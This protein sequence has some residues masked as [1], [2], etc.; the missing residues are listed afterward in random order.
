MDY[1]LFLLLIYTS[2]FVISVAV[3]NLKILSPSIVFTAS[4]SIMIYLAYAT[5]AAMG[6]TVN[7]KTFMIFSVGGLLFVLTEM[8]VMIMHKRFSHQTLNG[9]GS[10]IERKPLYIRKSTLHILLFIILF[11]LL[12]SLISIYLSTS[13]SVGNRM[14]TY[15]N[16]MI[17]DVG[18]VR[19][20]FVLNQ[21][22]KI[23]LATAYVCTYVAIYNLSVCGV[24][25]RTQLSYLTITVIF[26][27]YTVFSQGARQP[28][29][30]IIVFAFLTY[31]AWKLKHRDQSKLLK[32]V[33][34]IIIIAPLAAVVFTKT[35][36]L[37]GRRSAER[38]VLT[39]IS[40]YFCGGL[41]AFNLHVDEPARNTIWGQSSFA[42]I[43]Q[44]LSKLGIVPDSYVASYH[45]F[46]LYGNTVTMFGRWYE[47]FGSAGVYIM[48]IIVALFFS[49]LFYKYVFPSNKSQGLH[50]SKIVYCKLVIALV[51]AGYDDRIRALLSMSNVLIILLIVLMYK[52]FV[53]NHLFF[54]IKRSKATIE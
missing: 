27:F 50:L 15:K 5:K 29:I 23:N 4:F 6:F 1:F 13:G 11:S 14:E 42:D 54:S 28:A 16:M 41:Y 31:F 25:F 48:T 12:L 34:R 53:Q 24:K 3:F 10:D 37:V 17:N 2:L 32:Q 44:M 20:R 7:E 9:A 46:N 45:S 18:N 43:Y 22:Y 52:A 33:G 35:A 30:E 21:L 36:E 38:H 8:I 39:Y 40:T 26:I 49:I 47:D 51:W 19:F